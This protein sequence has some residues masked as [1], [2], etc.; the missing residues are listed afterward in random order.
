MIKLMIIIPAI[1]LAMLF[2]WSGNRLT[3]VRWCGY[4]VRDSAEAIKEGYECYGIATV[5]IAIAVI[6]AV[7]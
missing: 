5:F 6:V 4:V 7:Y 3:A 2:M 1:I